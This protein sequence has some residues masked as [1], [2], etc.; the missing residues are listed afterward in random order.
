MFSHLHLSVLFFSQQRLNNSQQFPS[1]QIGYSANTP[2]ASHTPWTGTPIICVR[3]SLPECQDSESNRKIIR[4]R[5]RSQSTLF[6]RFLTLLRIM[7]QSN[8]W[9]KSFKTVLSLLFLYLQNNGFDIEIDTYMQPDRS[10]W[11]K[12]VYFGRLNICPCVTNF[13]WKSNIQTNI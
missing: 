11:S 3:L 12:E 13:D 2:N 10:G 4:F 7:S 6:D 9:K 5:K 1:P 8:G